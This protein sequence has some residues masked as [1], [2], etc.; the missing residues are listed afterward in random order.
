MKKTLS[1]LASIL[2]FAGVAIAQDSKTDN[3]QITISIPNI[4]LLDIETAVN[5]NFNML[6]TQAQDNE[7]GNPLDFS[8]T[9]SDLWLNYTSVVSSGKTRKIQAQITTGSL[10]SGVSLSVA[11]AT[12]STGFGTRGTGSTQTLKT[13]STVD[14]ITGIGSC[15][16]GNGSSKGSQL[17]YSIS[18]ANEDN[19]QWSGLY[20]NEYPVT[21]TYT[22]T[23]EQ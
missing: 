11:G 16:T 12:V 22:I 17:T 1:I 21:V 23:D 19:A 2:V 8:A 20:T 15:Y 4:A 14:L 5:K 3:H 9:N 18:M 10:P 7:A 13:A 6:V